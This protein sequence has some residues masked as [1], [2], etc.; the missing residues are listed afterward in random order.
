VSTF[1]VA[2]VTPWLFATGRFAF[3]TIALTTVMAAFLLLWYVAHRSERWYWGLAAGF[4]LGLSVYSYISAWLYAPL[5]CLALVIAE[6][7]RPRLRLLGAAAVGA[8]V[9]TIPMML[10]LR[11]HPDALTARYQVVSLWL[12]G[13]PLPENLG[14]VWRVYTSGFSPEYLF[15]QAPWVLGGEFLAILAPLIV[16]GLVALWRDSAAGSSR[17]HDLAGLVE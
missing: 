6:L 16:V 7:P 4:V 11:A 17:V 5:L 2:S 14:R 10:F 3:E 13:Q 15:H 1:L 9:A 12:P 8:V